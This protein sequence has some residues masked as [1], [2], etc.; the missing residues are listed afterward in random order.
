MRMDL[1]A[2]KFQLSDE[3]AA[4][5]A[6][7]T[8]AQGRGSEE[9]RAEATQDLEVLNNTNGKLQDL[10]DG[11]TECREMYQRSWEKSYRPYWLGNN[12]ARYDLAVDLWVSRIDRMRS[13]QRQLI[14]EHSLPTASV[15]GIPAASSL[16]HP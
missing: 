3:I 6:S 14:Y 13:A 10:R 7:A 16:E 2:Y 8:A 5:Y 9:G 15:M 12:L 1:L 4:I 11:Y